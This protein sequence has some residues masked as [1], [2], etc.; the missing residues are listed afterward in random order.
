MRVR[1]RKDFLDWTAECEEHQDI[2]WCSDWLSALEAAYGHAAMWHPKVCEHPYGVVI[3]GIHRCM[4]C[5]GVLP[6]PSNLDTRPVVGEG[7]DCA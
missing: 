7:D 5:A 4:K 1:V 3:D 2:V 6:M